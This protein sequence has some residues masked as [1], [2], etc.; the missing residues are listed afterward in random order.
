[1]TVTPLTVTPEQIL[2]MHDHFEIEQLLTRY[3]V[4]I[5]TRQWQ[6]L[7]DLFTPDATLDYSSSGAP[8]GKYAEIVK[9]F[10][11]FLPQF[12]MNQHMTLNRLIEIDGD[13]ATGRIYF[14]NPNSFLT[15]DGEARLI[16]VGGFYVDQYVRTPAGWRIKDRRQ[17]TAWVQSDDSLEVWAE[18][19]RLRDT[20]E[21]TVT[22][23]LGT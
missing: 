3:G 6:L 15:D 9:W 1:M 7:D 19:T 18:R 22:S 17:E 21:E 20:A 11:T 10:A 2:E 16:T 4:A 14:L 12:H 5:D 13:S 8:A 23:S